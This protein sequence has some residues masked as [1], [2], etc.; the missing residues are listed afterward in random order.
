MNRSTPGLPVHHQLPEFTQTHVHRV[1]EF[2]GYEFGYEG[3][4]GKKESSDFQFSGQSTWSLVLLFTEEKNKDC[5]EAP[6][7]GGG[8]KYIVCKM[9]VNAFFNQRCWGCIGNGP[10]S[11]QGILKW[12]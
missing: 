9:N 12:R 7:M 10:D 3:I 11:Q 6:G 5:T 1:S 4:T 8:N 2:L